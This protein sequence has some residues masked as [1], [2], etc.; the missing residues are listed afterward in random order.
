MPIINS[1]EF[2]KKHGVDVDESLSLQKISSL[3][4]FPMKALQ[5]VFNR[6][7]GAFKTNPESVRPQVQ[8][9]EQWAFGRVYSFVMKRKSTFGGADKDIANKYKLK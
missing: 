8:S 1:R 4:G 2:K 5:E 9:A 3:S 6:G 7:V